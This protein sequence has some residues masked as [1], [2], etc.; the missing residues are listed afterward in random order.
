MGKCDEAQ[1]GGLWAGVVLEAV[2]LSAARL[3][4]AVGQRLPFVDRLDS[5]GR[6]GGTAY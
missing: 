4:A 2:A 1:R 5:V 3:R 6:G